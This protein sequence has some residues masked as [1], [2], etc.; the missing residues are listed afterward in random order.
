[1]SKNKNEELV[2]YLKITY[3]LRVGW[4]A[5]VYGPQEYSQDCK[6]LK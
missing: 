3:V 4:S 1:M 5:P 6:K 2:N